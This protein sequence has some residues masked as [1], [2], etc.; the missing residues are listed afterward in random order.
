MM[1]VEIKGMD[2]LRRKLD[3]LK[4]RAEALDG[5]HQI[6][7]SEIFPDEFMLL[8]TDFDSIGSMFEASGFTIRSSGDLEAVPPDEWNAFVARR[9]RFSSWGE[10]KAAA[11]K[12]YVGSRLGL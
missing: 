6:P 11:M 12:R 3:D 4:R 9:T 10:M 5:E 7:I 1:K 2:G 8:N